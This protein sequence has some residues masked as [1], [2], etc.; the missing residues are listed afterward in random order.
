MKPLFLTALLL[1]APAT[2]EISTVPYDDLLDRL[3]T[4]IGFET[5]PRKPEPGIRLD[6]PIRHPGIWIGEHFAGQVISGAP[7]DQLTVATA[8]RPLRLRPGPK[9]QN[10]SVAYHRGFG[11][12]ALF[13]LG[14]DGFDALSGRGE[15]AVAILFDQPQPE[16][17][18]RLHS[19]YPDPLGASASPG[20]VTV[21]VFNLKGQPF[22]QH[23]FSPDRG[24]AGHG[25]ACSDGAACIS[26]LVITNTDPGGIAIDDIL[27]QQRRPLF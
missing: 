8:K 9:N 4:R 13:P 21:H 17:G 20:T 26:G 23:E 27:F 2:A 5:L 19:G 24:P 6:A 22:A 18:F 16:T 11:S 25:F 7:H 10:L 1:A 3:D 14:P 15:G 12:N